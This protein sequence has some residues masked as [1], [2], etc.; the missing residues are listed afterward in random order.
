MC[1]YV[2]VCDALSRYVLVCLPVQANLSRRGC[3]SL[4]SFAAAAAAAALKRSA[5]PMTGK[6]LATGLIT[7]NHYPPWCTAAVK[8]T[9]GIFQ[10]ATAEVMT[11]SMFWQHQSAGA[12]ARQLQLSCQ[13]KSGTFTEMAI[14]VHGACTNKNNINLNMQNTKG[15]YSLL[16]YL[17]SDTWLQSI[18][19]FFIIFD[20]KLYC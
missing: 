5:A 7:V 8:V 3:D 6:T 20:L 12:A 13:A 11:P 2:R 19:I 15:V 14:N 16:L 4:C 18:I 9:V 10:P 1:A 17:S